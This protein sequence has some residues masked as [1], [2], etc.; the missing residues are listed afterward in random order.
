MTENQIIPTRTHFA[1]YLCS[2][3]DKYS[4]SIDELAIAMG[5]SKH[6]ITR[7]TKGK[8]YPTPKFHAEFCILFT[9]VSRT[10]FEAYKK[11][12]KKDK[13]NLVAKILA[14]GG[15]TL[16]IGGMI[17]LISATGVIGGL[18]AAGVTSG[19]AA[20]G[21][22]VGGGMVAGITLIAAAPAIVGATI[23]TLCKAN[24]KA[25][26]AFLAY[27]FELDPEFEVEVN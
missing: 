20:I 18:S 16:T 7:L 13:A 26:D 23:Y 5:V 10:N 9:V 27:Q 22:V 6:T 3:M 24:K 11:I 1:P 14:G 8:S 4:I 25:Q 19:L 12:S 2:F 15:S 17:S 21:G